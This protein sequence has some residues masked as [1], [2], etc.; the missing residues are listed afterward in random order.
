MQFTKQQFDQLAQDAQF[1]QLSPDTH[2]QQEFTKFGE[3]QPWQI[4]KFLVEKLQQLTPEKIAQIEDLAEQ[5]SAPKELLDIVEEKGCAKFKG[6]VK[7]FKEF[8]YDPSAGAHMHF[9]GPSQGITWIAHGN[10]YGSH[11]I[12]L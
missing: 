5:V 12:V 7:T 2:S 9:L 4:L 1:L 10:P 6:H 3:G 8:L 11:M